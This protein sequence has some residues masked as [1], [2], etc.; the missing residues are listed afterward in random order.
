MAR[1]VG[2]NGRDT[3]IPIHEALVRANYMGYYEATMNSVRAYP[4]EWGVMLIHLVR[5]GN[6][7]IVSEDRAEV[8]E[9][10][11]AFCVGKSE[12]E[13]YLENCRRCQV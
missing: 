5:T 4:M 6:E 8:E 1:Y 7:K 2:V 11:R 10:H 13:N 12:G 3:E 9:I